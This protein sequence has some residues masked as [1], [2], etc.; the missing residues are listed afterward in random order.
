VASQRDTPKRLR[1]AEIDDVHPP[2]HSGKKFECASSG[3]KSSAATIILA[4]EPSRNRAS[5]KPREAL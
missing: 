1:H 5:F 2:P 4:K 3:D